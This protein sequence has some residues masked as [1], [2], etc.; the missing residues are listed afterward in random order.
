MNFFVLNQRLSEGWCLD[1]T[2]DK[3]ILRNVLEQWDTLAAAAKIN[4]LCIFL[5]VRSKDLWDEMALI[6][7]RA[8]E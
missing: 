7:K 5:G 2:L 1:V 6:L 3:D 8:L 4:V